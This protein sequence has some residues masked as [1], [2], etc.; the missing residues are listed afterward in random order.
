LTL[1]IKDYDVLKDLGLQPRLSHDLPTLFEWLYDSGLTDTARV[2]D[3][4]PEDYLP[5]AQVF[6]DNLALAQA[7]G[8]HAVSSLTQ[9]ELKDLKERFKNT[10]PSAKNEQLWAAI[11]DAEGTVR[12]LRWEKLPAE[13][14]AFYRP[15]HFPP[16]NQW[17]I[18]LL[19][20]PLL[21]YH[22]QLLSQTQE[23]QLFSS[24]VLMHLI[25]FEIFNHEFFHHLVESTATTLEILLAAQNNPQPIYLRH[26]QQQITNTFCHPHA[27]LE[28]A[29]ANA[30][31]YNALGFISRI[32]LGYKTVTVKVYQKAIERHWRFEPAGYCYA[33]NYIKGN[34]ID[35]GAQLLANLLDRPRAANE[36]PLSL[37]AKHVMPSGFTSLL[38]KPDVPTWLVGSDAELALF[39]QLVPAPNEA[40]TQ[41]FWP[42]NTDS[43]DLFIQ[44]KK[45]EEKAQKAAKK[46]PAPPPIK[47]QD[48]LFG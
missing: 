33:G 30:Y 35:G 1:S 10:T 4:S 27:P 13:A 42:Y 8:R 7:T 14:M 44:N 20:G 24:E 16:F 37:I 22:R 41:L 39:K 40:Y 28:E 36:V 3:C 25:V 43:Q 21:D 9:Q 2:F 18:Y 38:A 12:T 31:A 17:G 19:I 26:R 32:K 11:K 45:A 6:C 5:G 47:D 46:Q 48:D 23:L 29:L 34:Y 15:F